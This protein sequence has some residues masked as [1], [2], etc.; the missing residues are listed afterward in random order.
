MRKGKKGWERQTSV[1]KRVTSMCT[2]LGVVFG[3]EEKRRKR[4]DLWQ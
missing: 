2:G 1:G 3:V 4:N